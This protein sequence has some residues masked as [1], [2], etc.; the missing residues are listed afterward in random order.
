MYASVGGD[1]SPWNHW[2]APVITSTVGI[3]LQRGPVLVTVS[4][5]VIPDREAEFRD[6]IH[7]YARIRRRDGAYQ[8]AV[9]R[10]TEVPHRYLEIF[11]VHSWAEHLRQ[12]DRQTNADR[13]LEQRILSCIAADPEVHHLIHSS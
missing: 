4:Y 5:N 9:F 11:R 8:W 10:Y 6:A 7:Q 13:D 1:L 12:H 2:R 3:D